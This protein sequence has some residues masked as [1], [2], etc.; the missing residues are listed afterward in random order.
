MPP[1][2]AANVVF[3]ATRPIP[4]MS[5]A[6]NVLPGLKPYHPNQRIKVPTAPKVRL[7]G[8]IGPP[9]SLLNLRPILG[10]STNAPAND[11]MPPIV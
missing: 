7:C 11:A 8:Y 1:E 5:T 6:D 10:P 3:A 2:Q 4:C 9:P